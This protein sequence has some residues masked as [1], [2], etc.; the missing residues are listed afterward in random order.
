[1]GTGESCRD[2][3]EGFDGR[4]LMEVAPEGPVPAQEIFNETEPV[5]RW[6]ERPQDAFEG[7]VLLHFLCSFSQHSPKTRAPG[8]ARENKTN[9][10]PSGCFW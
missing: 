7:P 4:G 2:V 9:V 1:M 10:G 8:H 6:T 5:G 3:T